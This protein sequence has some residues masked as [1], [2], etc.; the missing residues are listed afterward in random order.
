MRGPDHLALEYGT[1]LIKKALGNQQLGSHNVCDFL[2]P[3][4][5]F[6]FSW[7]SLSF[8]QISAFGSAGKKL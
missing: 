1:V 3:T 4:Y 6:E 2:G 7:N 8:I 5:H